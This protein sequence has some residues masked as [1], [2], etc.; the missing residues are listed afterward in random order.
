MAET[1]KTESEREVPDAVKDFELLLQD[2]G[3][4]KAPI[5]AK[6]IAETGGSNVFDKPED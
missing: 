6:N 2:Y 1:E 3:I 5:I 4:K